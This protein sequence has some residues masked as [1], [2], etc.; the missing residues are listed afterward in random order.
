MDRGAGRVQ[1]KSVA[2]IALEGIAQEP[3]Q[4]VGRTCRDDAER[5][6]RTA[7]PIGYVMDDAIPAHRHDDVESVRG[8][9]RTGCPC[10][11]RGLGPYR[12]DIEVLP[13]ARQD[14]SME[15]PGETGRRR[16][17]AQQEPLHSRK[18]RRLPRYCLL[19]PPRHLSGETHRSSTRSAIPHAPVGFLVDR[20]FFTSR[21][22]R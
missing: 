15:S 17:G 8:G 4:H 6:R 12:L 14:G 16:I 5:R 1:M 7:D 10:V 22:E 21:K 3:R 2:G 13:E 20:L 11:S 9:R 18:G 19:R